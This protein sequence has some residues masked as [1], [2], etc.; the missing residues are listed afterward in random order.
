MKKVSF[1]FFTAGV[2][3]KEIRNDLMVFVVLYNNFGYG[4]RHQIRLPGGSIQFIDII[5]GI[6]EVSSIIKLSKEKLDWIVDIIQDITDRFDQKFSNMPTRTIKD[7]L[8]RKDVF[9]SHFSEAEESI[10][11]LVDS[12]LM[13]ENCIEIIENAVKLKTL[14]RELRTEGGVT[15]FNQAIECGRNIK[16]KHTQYAYLV[17]DSDAPDKFDGSA[18]DDIEAAFQWKLSRLKDTLFN[19]HRDF[20]FSALARWLSI[21]KHNVT[22]RGIIEKVEEFLKPAN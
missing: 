4:D 21:N 2:C 19:N 10:N 9:T 17:L 5:E 6:K 22:K 11:S 20:L 14:R 12:G 7:K 8:A 3:V 15:T 16:G 18:D 1:N 13:K